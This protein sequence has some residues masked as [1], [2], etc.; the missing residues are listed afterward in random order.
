MTFFPSLDE[1]FYTEDDRN[2]KQF[3][4]YTY[5]KNI[6][7]N[8]S[9]W[10]EASLD[11][12]F[13]ANDQS[14]WQSEYGNVP[15]INRR[16]FTFN[17]MKPIINMITGYQR[18]NRKSIES[19]PVYGDAN[20]TSDQ[21]SRVLD[22][23]NKFDNVGHTF[24]EAFEGA[25]IAGMNLLSVWLDYR[26]DPVNGDIRVDNVGYNAYL[27]DPFMKK[28]DLSD[29][30][31]LWTRKFLSKNQVKSL[32]PDREKEIDAMQPQG[33]R[34]GKFQFMPESYNYA[35]QDLLIYDEFWY[36]RTR[37][38]KVLI[39][40]QSGETFEWRGNEENL[41]AFLRAY[42]Q[43]IVTESEIPTVKLAIKV[44][45]RVM[46]NGDNPLNI[47][48][49]PFV[50]VWAYYRPE[51]ADFP[52]R[53]QGVARSLRDAQYLYN[54]RKVIEL[55]IMESQLNSGY[56]YKPDSLVDV[57]D[58]FLTGQ[59]K[60]IA[61][62]SN[63]SLDDLRP[64]QAPRLDPSIIQLSQILGNEMKEISGVNEELLGSADDDKAGILS[65]LRQS[66]G[67]TGQQGLLDNA[68]L[69]MKLLGEV[70]Q[71][72][73]MNNWTP[74]KIRRIVNEEPTQE[75]YNRTFQKY[76]IRIVEGLNTATQ[77]QTQS[78][79]ILA[80]MEAGI[81]PNDPAIVEMAL[82]GMTIQNKK[83]IID[84][85]RKQQ[86]QQAQQQLQQSQ[87]QEQVLQ[88][89]IGDLQARAMANE[90]LGYERAS[91]IQENKALAVERIAEAQKD[92]DLGT[93]DR[94]KAFKE[95][96]EMDYA[97][98]ERAIGILQKLQALQNVEAQE[99]AE[100]KLGP[101]SEQ[102]GAVPKEKVSA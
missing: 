16:Q 11:T 90:G 19:I 44:Q 60:G 67:L 80:L 101:S 99:R 3:M 26:G 29:C 54:R 22:H 33:N 21:M 8:Q 47:D 45:D 25:V 10:S 2:I 68:D 100:Q 76:Q 81:L 42:P 69:A 85:L 65:L 61:I 79:Q 77:K 36:Q 59:G 78:R 17:K 34:D 94:V 83:E 39:D 32:L 24:S 37:K 93:L 52:Y 87:T 5:L 35:M 72:L 49:Y 57:N 66:A 15:N 40:P 71:E 73:V 82:E 12:R 63:A 74:G 46:Y 20:A 92:R 14:V 23:V 31:T 7:I 27:I 4:E 1:N 9:F 50:P 53:I 18:K 96:A 89:Q 58:I 98:I 88:A 43:I 64:I 28:A 41:R 86:E 38:Q 30:E 91:R 13:V 84:V 62:Q 51:L 56:V 6:Q 102:A 75:F 70:Q 55:D 95:I 97:E 48:R